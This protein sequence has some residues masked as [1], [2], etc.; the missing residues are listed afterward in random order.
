MLMSELRDRWD[1]WCI[2][3]MKFRG[4]PMNE[5]ASKAML[6]MLLAEKSNSTLPTQIVTSFPYKVFEGHA[7]RIGLVVTPHAIAFYRR[8]IVGYHI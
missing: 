7:R 2:D 4:Q 3:F 8:G 1:Q 5:D 6:N